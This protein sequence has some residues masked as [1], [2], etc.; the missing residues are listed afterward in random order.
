MEHPPTPP[1]PLGALDALARDVA[2]LRAVWAFCHHMIHRDGWHIHANP[3]AVWFIPPPHID[4]EQTPRLGG[5]ARFELRDD[6]A[7]A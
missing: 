4:P 7:A 3:T 2:A 6:Q 1:H 5:R